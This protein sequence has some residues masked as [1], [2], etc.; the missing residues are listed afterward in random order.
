MKSELLQKWDKITINWVRSDLECMTGHISAL[1][2]DWYHVI[3]FFDAWPELD[4]SELRTSDDIEIF[5][6]VAPFM[7]YL[8]S[9]FL[10]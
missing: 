4:S 3:I 9:I 2:T 6:S 1:M 8:S 10:R 5:K 7:L